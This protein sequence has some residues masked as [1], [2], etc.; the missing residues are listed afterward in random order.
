MKKMTHP[1]IVLLLTLC[2]SGHVMSQIKGSRYMYKF[3]PAID[4]NMVFAEINISS[5]DGDSIEVN[6][7]NNMEKPK[8]IDFQIDVKDD[9]L[10]IV[11][12]AL[13]NGLKGTTRIDIK[14]P[15]S[16]KNMIVKVNNAIQD[17]II[18]GLNADYLKTHAATG[19]ITISS[20]KAKQVELSTS[21]GDIQLKQSEIINVGNI[22]T[23]DGDLQIELTHLPTEKLIIASTYGKVTLLVSDFGEN[24]NF[25]LMK[26]ENQ[27]GRFNVPFECDKTEI[28]KIDKN[29]TYKTEICYATK[30]TGHPLIRLLTGDG[31][32]EVKSKL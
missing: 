22:V 13:E 32:V 4:C 31:Q 20:S 16:N 25:E 27:G 11:E 30:G 7:V 19:G 23:S 3:V 15:S 14:I 12:K 9:E 28:K 24:Y 21:S 17:I 18:A 29:D 10:I 6:Y 2:C 26:N 8:K 5:Y 1:L